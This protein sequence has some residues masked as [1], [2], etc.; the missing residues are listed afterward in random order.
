[1][2][3]NLYLQDV[4]RKM[5]GKPLLLAWDI[6]QGIGLF[7][8]LIVIIT[9]WNTFD[10]NI[11]LSMGLLLIASYQ[12]IMHFLISHSYNIHNYIGKL[13]EITGKYYE[14]GDEQA[15]LQYVTGSLKER[16]VLNTGQLILT[17]DLILGYAEGDLIFR[18]VAI[19]RSEILESEFYVKYVFGKAPNRG[20]LK[21]QLKNKKSLDLYV[22]IGRGRIDEMKNL[23]RQH[24]FNCK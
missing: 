22:T 9:G 10:K 14:Y 2:S 11:E 4:L 16:T 1:M 19:P 24:N 17:E 12:I 6:I 20:V 13:L 15:F 21:C 7:A 5:R 23:L 8:M 18:P 3:E